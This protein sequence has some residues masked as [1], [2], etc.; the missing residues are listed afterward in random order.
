MRVSLIVALD[1]NGLIG[2]GNK[3]PWHAPA[4]LKHFKSVTMGKPVVMGRK[5]CESIAGPLPGRRNIV[6]T[7][8]PAFIR[9]GFEVCRDLDSCLAMLDGSEEVMIIGG[10]EI[11]R[12]CWDRVD[13]IYATLVEGEFAGDTWFP[14]WPLGSDWRAVSDEFRASDDRTPFDLRFLVFEKL[15]KI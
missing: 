15:E 1:K 11:Y 10:A 9:D 6:L 12:L 13:R 14:E 3:L 7:R 4:D 2:A 5:T 8:N